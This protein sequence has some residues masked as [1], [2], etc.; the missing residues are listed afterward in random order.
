MTTTQTKKTLYILI[1][2]VTLALAIA[3]VLYNYYYIYR[4]VGR[5]K[6]VADKTVPNI[7]QGSRIVCNFIRDSPLVA[8]LTTTE[9][10]NRAR[11]KCL[12]VPG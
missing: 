3:I 12:V 1:A 2:V 10:I 6:D 4:N 11:E 8:A 9:A 5:I 7:D